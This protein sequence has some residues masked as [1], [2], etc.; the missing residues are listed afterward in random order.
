MPIYWSNFWVQ[1]KPEAV[2]DL[3]GC[4]PTSVR[5]NQ[6]YD[7]WD[8][9]LEGSNPEE[10]FQETFD[11]LRSIRPRLPG[12]RDDYTY[13]L[14]FGMTVEDEGMDSFHHLEPHEMRELAEMEISVAFQT[15]LKKSK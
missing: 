8:H 10:V 3:L 5:R 1:G 9:G 13:G 12:L 15:L 7:Y 14:L 11:F 2:S 6:P 4:S